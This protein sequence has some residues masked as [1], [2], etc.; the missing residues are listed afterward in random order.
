MRHLYDLAT[1][2]EMGSFPM[3]CDTNWIRGKILEGFLPTEGVHARRT[4]EGMVHI[5]PNGPMMWPLCGLLQEGDH[6]GMEA[7]GAA[8]NGISTAPTPQ[9]RHL[10]PGNPPARAPAHRCSRRCSA[11]ALHQCAL[12][13]SLLLCAA[14]STH[15]SP[16]AIRCERPSSPKGVT[17]PQRFSA[18]PGPNSSSSRS[19]P[20][21]KTTS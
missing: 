9:L 13:L 17:T 11:S 16:P 18:A 1:Q 21:F 5:E 3:I 6:L 15:S 2:R 8:G 14:G 10:H 4:S 7:G 19:L 12:N 20:D